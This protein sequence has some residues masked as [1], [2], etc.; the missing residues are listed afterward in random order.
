MSR[1]ADPSLAPQGEAKIE[2]AKAWMP[3]LAM[4]PMLVT[5][6][7]RRRQMRNRWLAAAVAAAGLA[8]GTAAIAWKLAGR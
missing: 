6:D 2:W 4:I 1:V 5:S 7:D 3:V 8:V